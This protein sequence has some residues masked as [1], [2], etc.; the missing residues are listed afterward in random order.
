LKGRT[1]GGNNDQMCGFHQMILEGEIRH[2]LPLFF[3]LS[4]FNQANLTTY[5]VLTA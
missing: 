2:F 5:Q 1:I 3:S 4:R